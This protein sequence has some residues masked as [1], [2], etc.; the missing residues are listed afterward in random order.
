MSTFKQ[1]LTPR[2]LQ[3]AIAQRKKK[4][5]VFERA[6]REGRLVLIAK[7]VIGMFCAR[8]IKVKFNNAYVEFPTKLSRDLVGSLTTDSDLANI[9]E[10]MPACTVCGIG[11]AMLAHLLIK[12]GV[13]L[14][15]ENRAVLLN[16]YGRDRVLLDRNSA[17]AR[18]LRQDMPP[19]LLDCI[20]DAFEYGVYGYHKYKGAGGRFI[21]IY[22]NLV[23]NKGKKFTSP[24]HGNEVWSW[25]DHDRERS[26]RSRP[27]ANT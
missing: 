25:D 7:D 20:E 10:Q 1:R 9:V 15:Q 19:T 12:D 5:Q 21:A 2:A 18:S 16:I 24:D 22:E 14:F 23:E 11:G 6:S 26:R 17:T 3:S 13:S 8:R 4:N 27:G